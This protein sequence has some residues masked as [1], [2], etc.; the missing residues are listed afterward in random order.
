M[1]YSPSTLYL[2]NANKWKPELDNAI[3]RAAFERAVR[4]RFLISLWPH[5]YEDIYG[6]MYSLQD[7]SDHLPCYEFDS[8]GYYPFQPQ[9]FKTPNFKGHARKRG[10]SK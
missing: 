6:L 5:T 4:V 1:D 7:I 8:T 3:R 9:S 2:K 10:L